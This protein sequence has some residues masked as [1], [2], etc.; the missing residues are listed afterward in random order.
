VAQLVEALWYKTEGCGF[1]SRWCHW[2][3]SLTRTFRPH[4]FTSFR[5]ILKLFGSEYCDESLLRLFF[6]LCLLLTFLS[7]SLRMFPFLIYFPLTNLFY[8]VQYFFYCILSFLEM[9]GLN[10]CVCIFALHFK[11]WI[12]WLIFMRIHNGLHHWKIVQL[13]FYRPYQKHSVKLEVGFLS[14]GV[15]ILIKRHC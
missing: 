12:R 5:I 15:K 4:I 3:F 2:N 14:S 9:K 11:L 8:F 10:L 13:L 1:D 6:P 7:L